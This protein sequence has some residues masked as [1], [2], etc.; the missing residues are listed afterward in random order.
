MVALAQIELAGRWVRRNKVVV[1][2]GGGPNPKG[3]G[4]AASRYARPLD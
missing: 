4:S 3:V 2:G 1:V